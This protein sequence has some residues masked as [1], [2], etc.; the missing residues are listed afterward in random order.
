MNYIPV[1]TRAA[2]KVASLVPPFSADLVQSLPPP[3][4]RACPISPAAE[5]HAVK[6][7]RSESVGS[8]LVV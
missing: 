6:A 3:S 7:R 4:K 1:A 2:S 8:V 5:N